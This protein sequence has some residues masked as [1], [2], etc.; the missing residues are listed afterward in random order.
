M[1]TSK[2]PIDT[3]TKYG[4]YPVV[5]IKDLSCYLIPY[6]SKPWSSDFDL[7]ETV[8]SPLMNSF[9]TG[10]LPYVNVFPPSR[11]NIISCTWTLVRRT[12]T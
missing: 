1:E 8:S 5:K 12:Q 6:V 9:V 4:G 2:T 7:S 10:E 3:L 11:R